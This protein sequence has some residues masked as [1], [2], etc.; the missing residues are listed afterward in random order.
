VIS[1][2][3]WIGLNGIGAVILAVCIPLYFFYRRVLR[4]IVIRGRRCRGNIRAS[5][6][7]ALKATLGYAVWFYGIFTL[8]HYLEHIRLE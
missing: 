5:I 8:A 4:A 6:L 2:L 7:Q 3:L 1:L